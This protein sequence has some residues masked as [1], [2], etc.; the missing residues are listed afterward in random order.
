MGRRDDVYAQVQGRA[1]PEGN[2]GRNRQI[3]TAHVAYDM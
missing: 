1:V 3:S 2:C